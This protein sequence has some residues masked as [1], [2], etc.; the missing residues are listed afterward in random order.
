MK[1]GKYAAVVALSGAFLMATVSERGLAF[2]PAPSGEALSL[3]DP[4]V[5]H[6]KAVEIALPSNPEDEAVLGRPVAMALAPDRLYIA[7]ALDCAIKVFSGEGRFLRSFGRKGDG[8][9]EL[10][11][12]SGVAAAGDAIVVA[13]KLNFRIQIFDG[14]G[15]TDGGFKLP[16]APDRVLALGPDRILVTANPTGR[17]K[18]EKLL[19]ILDLAG[20]AVWHGLE[21]RTSSDPVLDAFRNM[22]L[23]CRGEAE[24]FYV[25]FRS[26]ERTIFHFSG[27][28]VPLGTIAVDERHA[29]KTVALTSGRRTLRLAGFC[30]SAARDRGR[31][32]LSA[33][34]VVSGRD[35]G[36][37]RTLSVVDA[38]GRLQAAVE[39]PCP[40]HRFLAADGRL[41]AVDDESALRIFEVGR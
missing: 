2:R 25:V 17:K 29:F 40:V 18:G 15:R 16:F 9:G 8:P 7:D 27:S 28:G 39:L 5:P 1:A 24:D 37:G 11:F 33:P 12:P 38:R 32:Y 34:E 30:W 36:P 4:S 21:A 10:N 13:D 23:V 22:I 41:F 3:F 20:R 26:G 31:F 6:L 35:L 14:E 19:H